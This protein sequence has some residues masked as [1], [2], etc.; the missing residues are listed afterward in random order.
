[1]TGLYHYYTWYIPGVQPVGIE[2]PSPRTEAVALPCRPQIPYIQQHRI[3]FLK[4][5][6]CSAACHICW[7]VCYRSTGY[8]S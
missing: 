4:V 8:Y 1:M 2:P 6:V 5:T 3:L 7:P